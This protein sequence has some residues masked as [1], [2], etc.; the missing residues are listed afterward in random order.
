MVALSKASEKQS[1]VKP[2]EPELWNLGVS[3]F[4]FHLWHACPAE[5]RLAFQLSTLRRELTMLRV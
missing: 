1:F 4:T 2:E 3:L 5:V